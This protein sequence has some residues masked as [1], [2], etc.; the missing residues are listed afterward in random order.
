[1]LVLAA[2]EE[3]LQVVTAAAGLLE[4]LVEDSEANLLFLQV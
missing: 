3:R 1:M 4:I 2:S